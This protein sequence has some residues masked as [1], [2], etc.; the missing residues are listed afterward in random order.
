MFINRNF[1]KLCWIG[2]LLFQWRLDSYQPHGESPPR[3]K[4]AKQKNQQFS[5]VNKEAAKCFKN[6]KVN[7]KIHQHGFVSGERWVK[8][9]N[10]FKNPSAVSGQAEILKL[11][12]QRS[13]RGRKGSSWRRKGECCKR[14]LESKASNQRNLESKD[15]Q[16]TNQNNQRRRG[17]C[18]RKKAMVWM[19]RWP[20]KTAAWI[21]WPA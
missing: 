19:R 9:K 2:Y 16:P 3:A 6:P 20:G 21:S 1:L 8:I 18:G 13:G 7:F 15:N 14:N 11:W 5:N 17:R 12:R 4:K 10:V